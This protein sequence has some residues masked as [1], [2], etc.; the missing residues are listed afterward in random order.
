MAGALYLG[1]DFGTSGV[2]ACLIDDEEHPVAEAHTPLPPPHRQDGHVSQDP[3]TWW[4]ALD[5]LMNRLGRDGAPLDRVARLAVDGTAATLLVTDDQGRPLAPALMYNDSSAAAEAARI[6]EVAPEESPAR[7]ASSSLAKLLRLLEEHPGA[8][9]ALHQADWIA[10]RLSGRFGLSDENNALKL[11]YDVVERRWPAWLN[12][13]ELDPRLLPEVRPPGTPLGPLRPELARQWGLAKD[14]TVVAGT[15]DSTAAVLATGVRE[16]GQAVTVLGSTLVLKVLS[17]A[18]VFASRYG[19]YSHRLGGLWLAGG[20]SNSGGAALAAFFTP[21]EIEA[22]TPR[23]RPERRTCLEYYPL[24]APGERFPLAD[25]DLP[26]RTRPR[27]RNDARF[28]QGLLEGIARIERRGYRLLE[29]LGAPAPTEVVS[30]GGGARNPAWRV[31]RERMLR[32]P[33]RTARHDQ[34]AFGAARLARRKGP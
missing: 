20:A 29:E 10:G 4:Q 5:T 22:L 13:L 21:A 28:L 1:L 11:G 18:P 30:I 32:L 14:A 23:L 27:P 19:V 8:R 25:P 31:I 3:E 34:P 2:R 15:T 17:P 6:A 33:V 7:G 24:P 16:T 12:G 9:H 26:P